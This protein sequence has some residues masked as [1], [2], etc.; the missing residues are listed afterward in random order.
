MVVI[1]LVKQIQKSLPEFL[2]VTIYDSFRVF[3]PK[4]HALDHVRVWYMPWLFWSSVHVTS[5]NDAPFLQL[6]LS[7]W[8]FVAQASVPLCCPVLQSAQDWSSR[9]ALIEVPSSAGCC[10]SFSWLWCH[11]PGL[12]LD[13]RCASDFGLWN[14]TRDA[15]SYIR[16]GVVIVDIK[17][18]V[19]TTCLSITVVGSVSKWLSVSSC[20]FEKVL[21]F[22]AYPTLCYRCIWFL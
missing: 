14:R 19:I 8:W 15:R 13:R 10:P 6:N 5:S 11:L 17:W 9:A 2:V 20:F 3:W 16:R 18:I 7:L 1:F 22:F 4:C 12:R 21:L